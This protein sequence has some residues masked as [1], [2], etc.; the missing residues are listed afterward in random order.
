[1][2][3]SDTVEGNVDV[4]VSASVCWLIIIGTES[5]FSIV[6]VYIKQNRARTKE[7][8]KEELKSNAEGESTNEDEQKMESKNEMKTGKVDNEEKKKVDIDGRI[9][10][11][12]Q[13]KVV[14]DKSLEMESNIITTKKDA[15]KPVSFL[16]FIWNAIDTRNDP[17]VD[18]S[19]RDF[20]FDYDRYMMLI[21]ILYLVFNCYLNLAGNWFWCQSGW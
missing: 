21:P 20:R 15:T 9:E 4:M 7:S 10:A 14:E 19:S 1:M 2:D 17:V 18:F 16:I 11:A 6:V 5:N 13:E 3:T 8:G 12:E